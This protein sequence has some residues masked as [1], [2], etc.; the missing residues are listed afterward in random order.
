VCAS[1]GHLSSLLFREGKPWNAWK[2][3]RKWSQRTVD[4]KCSHS[5]TRT[6]AAGPGAVVSFPRLIPP[7]FGIFS[8]TQT[9]AISTVAPG[10]NFEKFF[11]DLCASPADEPPDMEEVTEIFKRYGIRILEPPSEPARTG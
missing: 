9:R 5:A 2:A 4:V 10:A 8:E 7:G 11:D 3:N 6:H 1:N